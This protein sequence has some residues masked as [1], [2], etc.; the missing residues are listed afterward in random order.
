MMPCLVAES[1][2]WSIGKDVAYIYPNIASERNRM[3]L[4]NLQ[5]RMT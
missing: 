2:E 5:E 3:Q 4:L 1:F